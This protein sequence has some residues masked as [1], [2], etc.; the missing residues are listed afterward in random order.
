MRKIRE[1]GNTSADQ[2]QPCEEELEALKKQYEDYLLAAK[3]ARTVHYMVARCKE[4][5]KHLAIK[6]GGTHSDRCTF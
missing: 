2:L 3:E 1:S 6:D 4:Q 5:W